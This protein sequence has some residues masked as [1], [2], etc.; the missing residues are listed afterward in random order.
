MTVF[1]TQYLPW[2]FPY[3]TIPLG[4]VYSLICDKQ[5]IY[6]VLLFGDIESNNITIT[7]KIYM[8]I[9]RC[10]QLLITKYFF[11]IPGR[12]NAINMEYAIQVHALCVEKYVHFICWSLNKKNQWTDV[13]PGCV[14]TNQ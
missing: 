14:I 3:A 2:K 6:S 8:S 10:T 12:R 13:F 1:V 9:G 4:D 11:G 7:T 5:E